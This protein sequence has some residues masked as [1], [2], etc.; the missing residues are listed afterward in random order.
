MLRQVPAIMETAG[1]AE[2]QYVAAMISIDKLDKISREG[3]DKELAGKGIAAEARIKLWNLLATVTDTDDFM[4][5]LTRLK[6][7]INDNSHKDRAFRDLERLWTLLKD[8]PIAAHIDFDATLARGLGYYTGCIFE[9]RIGAFSS[10]CGGGGRYDKLIGQFLGEDITAT[11]ISLGIERILLILEERQMFP[12]ELS[13][14]SQVMLAN[15]DQDGEAALLKLAT[16]I[17]EIGMSCEVYPE[18]QKIGKQFK[19]AEKHGIPIV[20][21]AGPDEREKGLWTVKN[22]KTGEQKTLQEAELLSHLK[23]I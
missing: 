9:L 20:V 6:H 18:T 13:A 7:Q 3:V 4:T 15:F 23:S 17:R 11:G 14:F 22:M 1:L 21:L 16:Q 2:D 19:Y 5:N 10:S 8:G 12:G